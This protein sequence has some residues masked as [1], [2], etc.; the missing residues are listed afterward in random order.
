MKPLSK[1]AAARDALMPAWTGLQQRIKRLLALF[2]D[3][4]DARGPRLRALPM[5]HLRLM[6]MA[7]DLP[8]ASLTLAE[9]EQFHPDP[10]PPQQQQL[11]Q[12]PGR[13]YQEI[14]QQARARLEKIARVVPI[15]PLPALD[16]VQVIAPEML[17]RVN[18][19]LGTRWEEVSRFEEIQRR[20]DE[21][22]RTIHE[23]ELALENFANLNL[24]LGALRN[25]TRFLDFYIGLVPRE[26]VSRLQGA[27]A[28]ADHLLFTY[29]QRDTTAHVIIVGP[30]G[31][32]EQQ[33]QSVL[34]SAGFQALEIP[35]SLAQQS[36]AELKQDFIRRRQ[37]LDRE[38][39]DCVAAIAAW[40]QTHAAALLEARRTLLL[41][42]PLVMLNPTIR[43]TGSLAVFSGWAPAQAVAALEQQ[44]H[45]SLHFPFALEVRDPTPEERSLVPTVVTTNPLL[46]PFATLVQQYGIPHYGEIDPTPLFALTFLL[47]FGMMFGDVGHGAVIALASWLARHRLQSF[48]YFGIAAGGS[49]LLFGL[50]FGSIFGVED[51]LPALWMAPLHDPILMLKVALLWGILFIVVA[52]GLG[53]YNRWISGQRQAALLAPH[54]AVNLLFYLGFIAGGFGLAQH[55]AFGLW[56]ALIVIGSLLTLAGYQWRHLSGPTGEKL[57]VVFIETLDTVIVYL[58]NTLSF[59][60]VSA[61][62][63]NHAA[64]ALAI[65]T[66]AEMLGSF[67]TLLTLIFGNLFILVLEGGIVM[68]QVMRLQYYEGFS[69]YFSGDGQAFAPLRL[70]A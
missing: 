16:Q 12:Q 60:R 24:D 21:D 50:I 20:L 47:M 44:L 28:L 43:G 36:P 19:Q 7:D 61:F 33:L 37:L 66:L 27:V 53:I 52:C 57:L 62:S 14:Y 56:P 32:K 67:G 58:S 70:R 13:D 23:Q 65:F 40:N 39:A 6:L 54:G 8:Q 30:T 59:L 55:G 11:G 41:A 38:R 17:V 69:R 46:R 49:S 3:R 42:E 68:I 48:A 9:T 34:S 64:L 15:D 51:W 18:D 45:H 5:K 4:Y 31:E 26:N 10:R 22:E 2:G 35:H 63:M 25:K 1:I 29:L